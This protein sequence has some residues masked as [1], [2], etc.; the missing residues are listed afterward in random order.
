MFQEREKYK[1][2][3]EKIKY[4][5]KEKN[6]DNTEREHYCSERE[7]ME[8]KVWQLQRKENDE[9]RVERNKERNIE[10][11]A[12]VQTRREREGGVIAWGRKERRD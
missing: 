7:V 2:C 9:G 10:L 3:Q 1:M 4:R 12:E 6:I 8:K 5:E 11:R